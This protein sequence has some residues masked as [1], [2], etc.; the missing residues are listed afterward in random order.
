[1]LRAPSLR[2]APERVDTARLVLQRPRAVDVPEIFRRYAGDL[3]ATRYLSWPVHVSEAQTRG[4]L[5]F[6]DD[7]WRRWPAGPYLVFARDGGLLGGTGLSFETPDCAATGYVFA[8]DAWGLGYATESLQAMVDVARA[9][10]VRLLY[11]VC[12]VDH[13]PSAHVLEKCGF[14]RTAVLQRSVEFPNLAPGTLCDVFKYSRSL[15]K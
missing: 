3:E 14:E 12:H 7:E 5:A 13:R 2:R 6:S 10:G 11:A 4:F 1:M 8:K 15:V 9:V